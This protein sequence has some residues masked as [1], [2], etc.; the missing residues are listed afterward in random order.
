MIP[1]THSKIQPD[2]YIYKSIFILLAGLQTK[3][4]T[5]KQTDVLIHTLCP[6]IVPFLK[7]DKLEYVDIYVS[8][9]YIFDTH[10]YNC[11][12]NNSVTHTQRM[13]RDIMSVRFSS[14]ILRTDS[15]R[16]CE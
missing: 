16:R 9:V 4:S 7:N 6:F 5:S 10:V 11:V 1:G 12:S 14:I 13:L 15:G 8:I 2:R 3:K